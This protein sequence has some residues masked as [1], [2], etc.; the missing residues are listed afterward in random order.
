[1]ELFFTNEVSKKKSS[2]K[3]LVKPTDQFRTEGSTLHSMQS[4]LY[5]EGVETSSGGR[6]PWNGY[7]LHAGTKEVWQASQAKSMVLG[8][9]NKRV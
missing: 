8:R 4:T 3:H 9:Q 2:T 1:M 5:T 6:D 7:N